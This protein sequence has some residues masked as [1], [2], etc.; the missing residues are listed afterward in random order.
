[1]SSQ[2]K[3]IKIWCKD[4]NNVIVPTLD[5]I[6][7]I[8]GKDISVMKPHITIRTLEGTKVT[9]SSGDITIEKVTDNNNICEF[10]IPQFGYWTI[11]YNDNNEEKVETL[12]IDRC[13]EYLL[14]RNH[15]PKYGIRINKFD[16]NPSTRVEYIYDAEGMLPAYMDYQRGVF[17]YG[18]WGDL[19]FIKENKPC[20]LK[21]NGE[22]DYYLDPNN[23]NLKENGS[24]SDV[25]NENYEGNAMSKIPLVWVNRYEDSTYQ[26]EIISPVKIDDNYKAY[27]H[28]DKNGN[29][30]D[31]FYYGMFGGSLDSN[32]KCR[33]L[34]NKALVRGKT[35]QEEI[36]FCQANGED[37]YSG[38]WSQDALIRTLCTLISRTTESQ[39]AFGKGN[40]NSSRNKEEYLLNTGTLVDKGQFY[41]YADNDHQVKVFHIEKFWGD[42][43]ESKAG[44]INSNGK[45]Y[46]KMTPE[47]EGY[48]ID[49]VD[50]YTDTN[51]TLT[52][53]NGGFISESFCSELGLLPTKYSGSGT[54]YLCDGGWFNNTA[55]IAYFITGGRVGTNSNL[56]GLY[57]FS[58]NDAP[59]K[60][61]WNSGV[62][63]CI[64]PTKGEDNNE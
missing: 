52:G 28:T 32:N 47:G 17:N 25:D 36:G 42:Q 14:D 41:G 3:T 49:N 53:T 8:D 26:Y 15:I 56:S 51:I 6:A 55:G 4:G 2:N 46:V 31:A 16:S 30:V 21:N 48:K 33:S 27:A 50:G 1:M 23:Y 61:N 64:I 60:T 44:V 24:P 18:D 59:N 9:V 57:S 34:S 13:K 43:W 5:L 62:R 7:N 10:E 35:K 22:V 20:M 40:T 12:L 29:I 19:W 39:T 37:W 54:T 11:S 38:T 58:T 63:P 45:L